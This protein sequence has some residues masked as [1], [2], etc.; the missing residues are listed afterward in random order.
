VLLTAAT[1]IGL[2]LRGYH[3]PLDVLGSWFLCGLLLLPLFLLPLRLGR[4]GLS[5]RSTRRS[6]SRTPSC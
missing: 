6:S 5:R 3:W 1:G 2:V 4:G